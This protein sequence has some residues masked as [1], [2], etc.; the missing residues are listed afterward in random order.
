VTR[1]AAGFETEKM[2]TEEIKLITRQFS[3]P[4]QLSNQSKDFT[5][6]NSQPPQLNNAEAI[7]SI[8]I[9]AKKEASHETRLFFLVKP[10]AQKLIE[11]TN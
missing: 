3:P 11:E 10:S 6:I 5:I 2:W 7:S 8:N 4:R 9:R 1:I